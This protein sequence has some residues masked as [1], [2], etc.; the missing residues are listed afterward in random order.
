MEDHYREKRFSK[1]IQPQFQPKVE[2][3]EKCCNYWKPYTLI[4]KYAHWALLSIGFNF[5][6]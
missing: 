2:V 1:K 5:K 4:L 3:Q 6:T